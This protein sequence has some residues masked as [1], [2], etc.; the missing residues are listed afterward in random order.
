MQKGT[1]GSGTA[2]KL[3]LG[4]LYKAVERDYELHGKKSLED[5]QSRW[6]LHLEPFFGARKLTAITASTITEYQRSRKREGAQN[7]TINREL[8]LLR[9]CYR[10][11]E[12]RARAGVVPAF[13]MLPESKPREGYLTNEQFEALKASALKR[14]VE[15]L[16]AFIEVAGR[17]A[18]RRSELLKLRVQD[19]D[20][21]N[22]Q[23]TF[24]ETKNGDDR[25]VPMTPSV[26]TALEPL[27]AN[28]APEQN[29]F[30]WSDSQPVRDFRETWANVTKDA[31]V[32][33]LLVHDLR[34]TGVRN[35]R[36]KGVAE[37]VAM[38]MSGH[39]TRDVFRRYNITDDTD[40]LDAAA[41]I[42]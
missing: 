29:V 8:A 25:R 26:R 38:K 30:R 7:A 14:G 28:Q 10:I 13:D 41:L 17:L 20:F 1:P 11:K 31:G 36:R 34:R 40:L 4:E 24:R 16:A 6:K 5:V 15:W 35:M 42:G 9:R 22:S 23:I 27:C 32:P 12:N 37:E 2:H 18:N 19:C 21:E 33:D 39:K 3:T